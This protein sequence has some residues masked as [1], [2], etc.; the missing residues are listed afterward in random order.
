MVY[1]IVW[2]ETERIDRASGVQNARHTRSQIVV[3]PYTFHS[4]C[5]MEITAAHRLP[6]DVP[7][8]PTTLGLTHL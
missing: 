5:I 1:H 8:H 6:H 2:C 3:L 7:V 4:R